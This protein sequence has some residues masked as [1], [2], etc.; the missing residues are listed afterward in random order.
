MAEPIVEVHDGK[1][2]EAAKEAPSAQ[3]LV[4]IMPGVIVPPAPAPPPRASSVPSAPASDSGLS[5]SGTESKPLDPWDYFQH[6][7]MP[8]DAQAALIQW[9][10]DS[11]MME[12]IKENQQA[13]KILLALVEALQ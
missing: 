4:E 1:G 6:Q 7:S 8:A 2:T 10:T 5:G 12:R 11:V 13:A 9:H 3:P